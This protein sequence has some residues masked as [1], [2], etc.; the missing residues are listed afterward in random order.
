MYKEEINNRVDQIKNEVNDNIKFDSNH[1]GE[2][3]V[4]TILQPNY[5]ANNKEANKVR[6]NYLAK[7]GCKI[8]K[9]KNSGSGEVKIYFKDIVQ[10]N[11]CID[12]ENNDLKS[13]VKFIIL[14]GVKRVKGL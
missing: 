1:K 3:I 7:V 13:K 12:R 4:E 5:K 2:I 10:V 11:R 8:E 6:A 9:I 14:N